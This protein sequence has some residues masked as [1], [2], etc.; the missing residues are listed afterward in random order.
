[1]WLGGQTE[2]PKCRGGKGVYDVLTLH[3]SLG[4]TRAHLPLNAGP[5]MYTHA[6]TQSLTDDYHTLH[7][8]P[9]HDITF[10]NMC[11]YPLSTLG[12]VNY[13]HVRERDNAH[14]HVVTDATLN[15]SDAL[16]DGTMGFLMS[17]GSAEYEYI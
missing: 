13:R 5:A 8:T 6:V 14:T 3:K 4:G 15:S 2:S 1:M 17:H 7:N 10:H 12:A 9:N 11:T 16:T